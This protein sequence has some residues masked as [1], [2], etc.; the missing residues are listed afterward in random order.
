MVFD[1][2]INAYHSLFD[3]D[4]VHCDLLTTKDLVYSLCDFTCS[5]VVAEIESAE[6]GAYIF[7]IN[8][9]KIRFRVAKITPTKV[10][11]FVTLW[12]RIEKGKFNHMMLLMLWIFLL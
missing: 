8:G 3:I 10:G 9:F 11:Q 6:Y 4:S 5:P 2:N 12:K 7:E 1:K